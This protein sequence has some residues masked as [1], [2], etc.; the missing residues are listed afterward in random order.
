MKVGSRKDGNLGKYAI[1]II[2]KKAMKAEDS[3][4]IHELLKCSVCGC[5]F[6]R[7]VNA[8]VNIGISLIAEFENNTAQLETM[9]LP[10][11][12]DIAYDMRDLEV[13]LTLH[14]SDD[15]HDLDSD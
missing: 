8:S 5:V 11:K 9:K 13:D 12:D 2:G 4:R 15:D 1:K 14:V 7:D 10:E 6:D 3:D